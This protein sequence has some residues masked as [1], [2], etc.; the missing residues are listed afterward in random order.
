MSAAE[1]KAAV[2]TGEAT[3]KVAVVAAEAEAPKA[4]QASSPPS[5]A[6]AEAT[7][8]TAVAEPVVDAKAKGATA[9]TQG[10]A[11]P[12]S[13]V[14]V[15]APAV[16]EA[17]GVHPE[18]VFDDGPLIETDR[19]FEVA[20][21]MIAKFHETLTKLKD[22]KKDGE[23]AQD[24]SALTRGA[25][26]ELLELRRAHR[27]MASAQETGRAAEVA[28]RRLVDAEFAHLETRR[29][30]C[31][32][33]RAAAHRCHG[34][35]TPHL[36]RLKPHLDDTVENSADEAEDEEPS[37]E[38]TK[39]SGAG[40]L[41]SLLDVERGERERLE[42][43]LASLEAV[44]ASELESIREYERLGA[45]LAGKL[46]HVERA[47]E[48]VCDTIDLRARPEGARPLPDEGV[49]ARLPSPLRLVFMKFD[50]L[51]TFGAEGGVAVR[52]EGLPKDGGPPPEKRQRLEGTGS[53]TASVVV[54]IAPPA[55]VKKA[56]PLS[57]RF[58]C[59]HPS[60]VTVAAENTSE[61]AVI[62]SLW[63][64]DDGKCLSEASAKL[65]VARGGE[66][67]LA[68][69]PY[70]WAQ[71]LAGLRDKALTANPVLL[72]MEGVTALDVVERVRANSLSKK[73]G[74]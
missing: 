2:T 70:H 71:V 48:P 15:V 26:L 17:N 6:K 32:C 69:C 64:E 12:D 13:D 10:A 53:L 9:E 50:T 21:E 45:E 63:P 4:S 74:N 16:V 28:A 34:Y 51:A 58:S 43:E 20:R 57:V 31:A 22:S 42:I 5:K 61:N 55:S 73:R 72:A 29:Y 3:A 46:K 14:V 24:V 33:N 30:E 60:F 37:A 44:K 38:A 68:G 19:A 8:V 40:R 52:I 47:L 39:Q 49:L 54:D 41:S 25:H 66:E 18:Q 35:P 62:G 36:D 7:A 27:A 65:L 1:K 11:T 23:E 67:T 56:K 59:Q